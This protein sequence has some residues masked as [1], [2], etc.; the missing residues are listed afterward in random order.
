MNRTNRHRGFTLAEVIA[1]AAMMAVLTTASFALV[2]TAH[3]AW[4][5][6]RDDSQQRR[7]AMA[8]LQHVCRRVRQAAQVSAISTAADMSGYLTLQMADG[9]S[10]LWDHDAATKQVLYGASTANSVLAEG[11]NQMNF[12][13]LTANGLGTTT[14]PAKIHSV[15]VTVQYALNR[16]SG[17][18][19][20]TV[21]SVGWLRA[22]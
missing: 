6:H 1:A 17:A 8:A 3:D 18:T 11:I 9:T 15:R 21:S 10:A 20:E 7:E 12:L 14:D 2:R 19:T 13:G 16:P 22:W 5:R 4:R